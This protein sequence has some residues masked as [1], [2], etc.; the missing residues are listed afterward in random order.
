MWALKE[1]ALGRFKWDILIREVGGSSWT[2]LGAVRWLVSNIDWTNIT[3][4]LSDNR[5]TLMKFAD[6]QARISVTALETFD[7]DKLNILFNTTSTNVAWTEVEITDEE[8]GT[9]VAKWTIY[10]FVNQNW[11]KTQVGSIVVKDGW[12]GLTLN[13]NYTVWL[14]EDWQGYI[15]FLT[16]TTLATT[17]DYKYTPNVWEQAVIDIGTNEL[18]NFEVKIETQTWSTKARTI[19]LSSATI[20]SDYWL[21]FLDVVEAWDI[22]GSELVFEWNKGSTLTYFDELLD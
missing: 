13:T 6:L 7:R 17:V 3:E 14:G 5:W 15:V 19:T 20:N 11:D 21:G 22:E 2:D 8:I 18:K 12:V 4:I 16:D 9:A 10:N 1:N